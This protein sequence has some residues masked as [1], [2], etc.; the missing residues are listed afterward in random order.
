MR[1]KSIISK[2]VIAI[3][4]ISLTVFILLRWNILKKFNLYS[5]QRYINSYGSYSAPIY[6]IIF[7]LRTLLLVFPFTVMVLLAGGLFGPRKGFFY[8][9][10]AIFI[11]A[12][13]AFFISRYFGKSTVQKLLKGKVDKLDLKIEKNGFR[14]IFFMR[15]SFIFPYDILNYAAGL[16]KVKY[17]DF[18]LGIM[19]GV[20]PETYSLTFLGGNVSHPF[21]PKFILAI[22][23]VILTIAL[24]FLYTRIKGKKKDD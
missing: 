19:L 3:L 5:L 7:A 17:R 2:I 1:H 12:N 24:P 11:S 21:S 15:A 20:I 16:T 14:I 10:I 9:M 6:I 23:L 18:I 4:S 8:S 22:L 13:I